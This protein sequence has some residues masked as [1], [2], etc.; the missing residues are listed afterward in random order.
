MTEPGAVVIVGVDGSQNARAA[1]RW[2]AT[3][4]QLRGA[5]LEL[6]HAWQFPAVA[7]VAYGPTVV[8]VFDAADLEK[9]AW[10]IAEAAAAEVRSESPGL[11]V[12]V[13][14]TRGHPAEVLVDAAQQAG[15]LVVG[16]RGLGGFARL[17]MGSTSQHCVH[18]A[19]CPVVVVPSPIDEGHEEPRLAPC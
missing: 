12:R 2:A 7:I 14:V 17:L 6:V 16:S 5:T 8:P 4:A 3:E 19:S 1:L 13:S 15:L 9:R 10:Q 18:H 11:D